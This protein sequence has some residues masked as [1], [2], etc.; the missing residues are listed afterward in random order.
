MCPADIT[1]IG[2]KFWARSWL[3]LRF[4]WAGCSE[5]R[6]GRVPL[7]ELRVRARRKQAQRFSGGELL[8]NPTNRSKNLL[9]NPLNIW[10]MVRLRSEACQPRVLRAATLL[11]AH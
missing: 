9:R 4:Y 3:D 1:I 8:P 5:D 11:P 6:A 7:R 2:R 10:Q